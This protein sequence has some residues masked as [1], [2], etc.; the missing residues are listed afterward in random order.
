METSP[1]A[2]GGF[3][4]KT[5]KFQHPKFSHAPQ[6]P[7]IAITTSTP[8]EIGVPHQ[9]PKNRV[10]LKQAAIQALTLSA[11]IVAGAIWFALVGPPRIPS[12]YET[13]VCLYSLLTGCLVC[14]GL[15]GYVGGIILAMVS[16]QN[17]AWI[18]Y[19]L[20]ISLLTPTLGLTVAYVQSRRW[21]RTPKSSAGPDEEDEDTDQLPETVGQVAKDLGLS[22]SIALMR[23][24]HC[25]SPIVMGTNPQN[26]VLCIPS[27]LETQVLRACHGDH[28]LS[29]ALIRLVLAHEISHV[30]NGDIRFLPLLHAVRHILPFCLAMIVIA[31]FLARSRPVHSLAIAMVTSSLPLLLL[32]A[33]LIGVLAKLALIQRERLADA[34]AAMIIKEDDLRLL[35]R[36]GDTG[37]S[38]LERLLLAFRSA[39]ALSG[40][41]MGLRWSGLAEPRWRVWRK[42][43]GKHRGSNEL[44]AMRHSDASR[45]HELADKLVSFPLY[46]GSTWLTSMT[47]GA[48]AGLFFAGFAQVQVLDFLNLAQPDRITQDANLSPPLLSAS[49]LWTQKHSEGLFWV[50]CRRML[51]P[52]LSSM[53]AGGILLQ[54]RDLPHAFGAVGKR[55]SLRAVS[56]GLASLVCAGIIFKLASPARPPGFPFHPELSISVSRLW[57]WTPIIGFIFLAALVLRR[58]VSLEL[59]RK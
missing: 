10:R 23:S 18:D 20:G 9:Q 36:R 29:Q 8:P 55:L 22:R 31:L 49:F 19:L 32:G 45:A 52:A 14:C 35:L 2:M 42:L 26:A 50:L 21:S 12:T 4:Y 1:A 41:I 48:L 59:I 39:S 17:A 34:T 30:R 11:L 58:N 56:Q 6:S 15:A 40:A 57:L 51:A 7:K 3:L 44:N 24:P 46:L 53:L 38:P 54:F 33:L 13:S 16:A 47:L 25:Y 37:Y 5:Q 43:W 27:P 28:G